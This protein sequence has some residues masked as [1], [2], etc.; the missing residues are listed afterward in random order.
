VIEK[1]KAVKH[2]FCTSSG[3]SETITLGFKDTS[4][5]KCYI[6]GIFYIGP[7]MAE[8]ADHEAAACERTIDRM[9]TAS[10]AYRDS[11]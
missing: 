6:L 10:T 8:R 7:H 9:V 3:P 11:L 1:I 5:G 2:D 4:E